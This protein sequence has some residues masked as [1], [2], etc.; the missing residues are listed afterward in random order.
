M[1]ICVLPLW[2]LQEVVIEMS[3]NI[4]CYLSGQCQE[5]VIEMSVGH[6]FCQVI[7][8]LDLVL[9]VQENLLPAEN[10]RQLLLHHPVNS[11]VYTL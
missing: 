3:Y 8:L 6:D 7:K 1:Y 9:K 11:K 5:V 4:T 2:P 10:K